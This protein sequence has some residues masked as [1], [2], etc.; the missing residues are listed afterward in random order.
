MS[1]VYI[2]AHHEAR[3]RAMTAVAD[4][5]EGYVI[6]VAPPTRSLDQNAK[7]HKLCSDVAGL[8]WYG[9]ARDKEEWK[10]L[11]V[12]GHAIATGRD[13]EVVTG[14]EGELVSIRESTASMS[15]ARSASLIDYTQAHIAQ[16]MEQA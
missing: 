14:F 16:H 11:F 13:A 6:K 4:A 10:T 8:P 3:R 15:K 5:P 12:S 9:K 2:L 1:A 7:F